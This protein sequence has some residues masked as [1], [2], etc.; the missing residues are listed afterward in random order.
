[1]LGPVGGRLAGRMQGE[2]EEDETADRGQG[3]KGL[4]LRGKLRSLLG[5]APEAF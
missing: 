5:R 2:P 3:P 4:R 1:M